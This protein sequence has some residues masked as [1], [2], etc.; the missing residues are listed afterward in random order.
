MGDVMD[1]LKN[2]SE[3]SKRRLYRL[4]IQAERMT[5]RLAG[6]FVTRAMEEGME[7]E[8]Q[9]VRLYEQ[10]TQSLAVPCGFVLH[11]SYDFCG[12][13]PDRMVDDGLLEVKS[14][15]AH[16]LL[17]WLEIRRANE[18]KEPDWAFIP[19]EYYDQMQKQMLCT[20]RQWC[21]FWAWHPGL[22]PVIQRVPRDNERIAI[23]EAQV[24]KLHEEIED[25]IKASGRPA[26]TWN[27]SYDEPEPPA[28]DYDHDKDFAD[29][30]YSFLG[31]EIVP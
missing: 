6:N 19:Q 13:S 23:L 12:A 18:G 28:D 2:G 27:G 22:P 11:P 30:D 8:E 29:Q 17:L 3:G 14:P 16:T 21:D 20:E 25:S 15:Q 10:A 24:C 1:L 9:A 31:G 7:R 5:G 4:K 26:T